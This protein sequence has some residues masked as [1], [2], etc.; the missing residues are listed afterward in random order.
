M[1]TRT[2]IKDLASLP[3]DSYV[4]VSGWVDTVRDQKKVQ[5][6]ILR[7][8]SGALQLVNPAVREGDEAAAEQPER[9]ALTESISELTQGSMVSFSGALLHDERV[10]LGGLEVKI[11]EMTVSSLA[12]PEPPIADDSSVDKRMDWR[13]LDLRRPEAQLIFKVQTTFEHAMR[14]WWVEN[15]FIEIHTPKLMASA[16]ESRAELYEMDYFDTTANLAQ[17]PQF[18]KKMA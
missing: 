2:L 3:H 11:S 14:S 8:E 12:Y 9:L 6:V 16:S 10:K 13:F 7:D 15:G 1:T 17:S 5:F 18:F 4:E